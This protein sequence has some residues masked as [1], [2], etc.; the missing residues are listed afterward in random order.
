MN[1]LSAAAFVKI[2]TTCGKKPLNKKNG[3]IKTLGAAASGVF[4]WC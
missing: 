2:E 3:T 4:V 1:K